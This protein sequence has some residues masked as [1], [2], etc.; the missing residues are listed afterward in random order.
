[1]KFGKISNVAIKSVTTKVSQEG[2]S[3]TGA[4]LLTYLVTRGDLHQ[5]IEDSFLLI[6]E[7]SNLRIANY[8]SRPIVLN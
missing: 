4:Y 5:T 6:I 3:K 1:M 8:N 2:N 7:N